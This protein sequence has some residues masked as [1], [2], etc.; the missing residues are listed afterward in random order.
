MRLDQGS[1]EP[2]LLKGDI[3]SYCKGLIQALQKNERLVE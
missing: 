1:Y 2:S 3:M